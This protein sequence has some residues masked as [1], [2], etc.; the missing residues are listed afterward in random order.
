MTPNARTTHPNNERGY[1]LLMVVFMVA[2]IMITTLAVTPDLITEGQREKEADMVWR[3][4]QYERAITLY[5]KKFGKYPTKIDDLTKETN[6]VRFLRHAY[7]DPMNKEDGS[8]RFIYVTVPGGQLV[9]S[10][11]SA[12]LLMPQATGPG[13]GAT[14]FTVG[15]QQMGTLGQQPGIGGAGQQPS[16]TSTT[17]LQDAQPQSLTG[18]VLGGNIIGV[19]SKIKKPS[20]RVYLGS[21]NY[22]LWEFIA[23]ANGQFMVPGQTPVNPN[24]AAGTAPPG[25]NQNGFGLNGGP[26]PLTDP[27][28]PGGTTQQPSPQQPN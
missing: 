4:E 21:D 10:L 7:T 14:P 20:I 9:G 25:P 16:P 27:N 17:G 12:T 23:S 18:A 8:W 5:L 1:T 11:K 22:Q 13:A 2:T 6:G 19:G 24:G 28:A 3:G 26:P 15:P